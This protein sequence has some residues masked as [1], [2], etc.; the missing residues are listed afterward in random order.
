MSRNGGAAERRKCSNIEWGSGT[1][2][3]LCRLKIFSFDLTDGRRYQPGSGPCF[4][5]DEQS[6]RDCQA[7]HCGHVDGRMRPPSSALRVFLKINV[8][9]KTTPDARPPLGPLHVAYFGAKKLHWNR[10]HYGRLGKFCTCLWILTLWRGWYSVYNHF[11][12]LLC[13]IFIGCT[14]N[15]NDLS[16]HR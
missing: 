7:E 1:Q 13:T 15:Q 2:R 11:S 12:L 5:T 3:G 9:S 8:M 14:A 4:L 10:P 6:L 16:Q